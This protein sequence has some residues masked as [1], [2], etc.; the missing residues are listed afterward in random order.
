MASIQIGQMLPKGTLLHHGSYRIDSY[1]ASGG[2]GNTYIA[3]NTAFNEKVAIKEFFLRGSAERTQDLV[4]IRVTQG[5]ELHFE[6]QKEKFKKEAQRIRALHNPHIVRVHDLFEDNGTVYYVMDYINGESLASRLTRNAGPMNEAEVRNILFQVLDALKEVHA[7]GL[8]HL[9]IKPDNILIDTNNQVFLIDFGASKMQSNQKDGITHTS[10]L[11][12]TPEYAP[13]ELMSGNTQN[14]GPWTDLYSLGATAVRLLTNQ[15]PP[16]ADALLEMSMDWFNPKENISE[17]MKEFVL[18][19]M[20]ISTRLRPQTAEE[21]INVLNGLHTKEQQIPS[22]KP[23]DYTP[24]IQNVAGS[25]MIL[26]AQPPQNNNSDSFINSKPKPQNN[27]L[28]YIILGAV[29]IILV[30]V[31]FIVL[32]NKKDND[33]YN[34]I[35]AI[36]DKTNNIK[37]GNEE[38]ID[39]TDKIDVFK[40]ESFDDERSLPDKKIIK[41]GNI[42][43]NMIRVESGTFRMGSDNGEANE[44]PVHY[45]T[46]DSYYIGETEVTQELWEYVMD[47][48]PSSHKGVDYPVENVSWKNCQDFISELNRLTGYNFRLPTEAEWEYAAKGGIH[49][50]YFNYSGSTNAEEVGW[51]K[52]NCGGSTHNVCTKQP[53]ALGVYDMTGNVCEWCQD[54]FSMYGSYSVTNPTGPVDGTAKV[55]RGG[56]WCNSASKNRITMRFSGAPSYSDHNLGFRLAM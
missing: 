56:G 39:D 35:E 27:N 18:R 4:S 10:A 47:Y 45:V 5:S 12:A 36:E 43:F 6:E 50:E 22:Q 8:R 55:G 54:W 17:S 2:F 15:N 14:I 34:N 28:I 21:A 48:N 9:D 1:L 26:S 19:C 3:T 37:E 44:T 41:V 25:T 32:G 7:A 42:P 23:L 51:I 13:L 24:P 20:T 31:L 30:I 40:Y 49:Q 11:T 46:L 52:S 16:T 38:N 33:T 53:N 29:A